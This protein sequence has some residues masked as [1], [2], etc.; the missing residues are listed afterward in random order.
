M[1]NKELSAE[2]C[3]A[4]EAEPIFL[5]WLYPPLCLPFFDDPWVEA[6][7]LEYGVEFGG[8]KFPVDGIGYK[9]ICHLKLVIKFVRGEQETGLA[10]H[11][12]DLGRI[13]FVIGELQELL[14]WLGEC[15]IVDV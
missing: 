9:I 1:L 4:R 10:Q 7:F 12:G 15:L 5:S 6:A 2:V 13:F 3:D 11:G 8:F 14:E